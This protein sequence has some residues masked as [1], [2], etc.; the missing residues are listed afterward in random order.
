MNTMTK[1]IL[2]IILCG[3]LTTFAYAQADNGEP[4][5]A[6]IN[7]IDIKNRMIVLDEKPYYMSKYIKV[8]DVGNRFP[9]IRD[10]HRGM[11]VK[12]RSRQSSKNGRLEVREIWI[13][14]L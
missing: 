1:Q 13:M 10:L 2:L 3:C 8:H 11:Y 14:P 7:T 5:F 6:N 4:V 9:S 12:F